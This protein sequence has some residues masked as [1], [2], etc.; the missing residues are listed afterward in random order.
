MDAIE[1]KG[2]TKFTGGSADMICNYAIE[3]W[4]SGLTLGKKISFSCNIVL[5]NQVCLLICPIAVLVPTF[6]PKHIIMIC[7]AGRGT[8]HYTR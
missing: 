1:Y 3:S 2:L 6:D 5:K 8:I 7:N 4:G